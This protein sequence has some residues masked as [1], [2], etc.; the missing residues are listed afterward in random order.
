[1]M[2][3]LWSN[4]KKT[5]ADKRLDSRHVLL[6]TFKPFFSAILTLTPA[7]PLR[8]GNH[9]LVS[10]HVISS[11]VIFVVG[12]SLLFEDAAAVTVY[13]QKSL[14]II[15]QCLHSVYESDA[16]KTSNHPREQF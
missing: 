9:T 1:M 13:V 14:P 7:E 10:E 15:P 2:L 4:K 5:P 3:A 8:S 16:S 12:A 6:A 11:D